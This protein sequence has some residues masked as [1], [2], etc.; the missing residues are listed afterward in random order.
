MKTYRIKHKV[1]AVQWT[2]ENFG[3]IQLWV[4][5]RQFDGELNIW[6]IPDENAMQRVE[7]GDWIVRDGNDAVWTCE[8]SAFEQ[9]Y[10]PAD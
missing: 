3:D 5:V 10:E 7:I 9:N 2:G 8:Q 4:P 6:L 1:Q